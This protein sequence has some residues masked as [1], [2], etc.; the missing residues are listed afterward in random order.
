MAAD[1]SRMRLLL[2]ACMLA[3]RACASIIASSTLERCFND[4]TEPL[5][6]DQRIVV[7]LSVADGQDGT[8]EVHAT[9]SEVRDRRTGA[10]TE[11][12]L[13]EPLVISLRKSTPSCVTR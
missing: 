11:V 9:L 5:G 4:G 13:E 2:S 7:A 3:A 1:R 10:N 8:E 12:S 6:C